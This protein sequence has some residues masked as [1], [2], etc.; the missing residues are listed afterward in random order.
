MSVFAGTPLTN[1]EAR[2]PET[3][4]REDVLRL[5]RAGAPVLDVLPPEEHEEMRLAGSVG[6]WLTELDGDAVA[7]FEKTEPI[8]VYCHDTL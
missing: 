1:L 6:I 8:I 3:I 4:G 7:R 5:A 2:I